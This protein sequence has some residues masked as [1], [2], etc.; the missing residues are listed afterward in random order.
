MEVANSDG[1]PAQGVNVVVDPGEVKG[2]TSVNGLARLSIN[3]DQGTQI[4]TVTVRD[5]SF[6]RLS[7]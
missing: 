4:I 6:I 1:S 7:V 2:R 5:D 3:T